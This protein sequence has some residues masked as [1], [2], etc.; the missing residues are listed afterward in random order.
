M[1]G[2]QS[3]DPNPGTLK[4]QTNEIFDLELFHQS[5]PP[6]PLSAD[7]KVKEFTILVKILSSFSD[8]K[9]EKPDS[10]WFDTP[11]SLKTLH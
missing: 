2:L 9:F 4:G 3:L 6:R 8:F 11:G 10:P 5:N 1:F 7:Q